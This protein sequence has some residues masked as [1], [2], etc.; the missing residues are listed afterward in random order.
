[1]C[2]MRSMVFASPDQRWNRLMD[3]SLPF[4]VGFLKI[5]SYVQHCNSPKALIQN[6]AFQLSNFNWGCL[7]SQTAGVESQC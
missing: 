4:H 6:P 5:K 1:M 3:K 2:Q 7:T